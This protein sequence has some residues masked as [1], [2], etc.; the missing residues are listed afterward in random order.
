MNKELEYYFGNIN[1]RYFDKLFI[2]ETPNIIYKGDKG[3]NYIKKFDSKCYNHNSK[4]V[5]C[6]K[7]N[8]NK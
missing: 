1:C 6:T 4:E 8:I 2:F 5:S 3:S 7:N